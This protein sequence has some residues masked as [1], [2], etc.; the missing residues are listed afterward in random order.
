MERREKDQRNRES[1]FNFCVMMAVAA[2]AVGQPALTH[3]ASKGEGSRGWNNDGGR[4]GEEVGRRY[5]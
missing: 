1:E 4:E 3:V 5:P 2:A